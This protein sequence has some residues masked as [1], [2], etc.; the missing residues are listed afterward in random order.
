VLCKRPC[1]IVT[2][3]SLALASL[4][5]SEGAFWT[6]AVDLGGERGGV[7]AAIV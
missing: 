6:T 7:S 5:T 2:C 4:G 3:F 1:W